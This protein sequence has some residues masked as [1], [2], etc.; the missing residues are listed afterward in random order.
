MSV[1]LMHTNGPTHSI[2]TERE[3]DRHITTERN[4]KQPQR[5]VFSDVQNYFMQRETYWNENIIFAINKSRCTFRFLYGFLFDFFNFVPSISKF[6][7]KLDERVLQF[8]QQN[9]H[10]H[11][12][13]NETFNTKLTKFQ[14]IKIYFPSFPSLART[15]FSAGF[16]FRLVC[17]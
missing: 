17:M 6:S 8:K 15:F 13:F 9:N 4:E 14:I 12:S 1:R 2:H 7:P 11:L 5:R 16:Q 10:T 3:S